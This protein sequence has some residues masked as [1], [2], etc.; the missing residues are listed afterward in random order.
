MPVE[1]LTVLEQTII[2]HVAVF[3]RQHETSF[4]HRYALTILLIF[5]IPVKL[6]NGDSRS[7]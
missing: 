6:I 2:V 4:V 3:K 1:D 7:T 5:M